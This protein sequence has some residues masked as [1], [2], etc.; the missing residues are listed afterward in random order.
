MGIAIRNKTEYDTR[1]ARRIV[2][3]V[4][5]DLDADNV[6]V[7]IYYRR[8]GDGYS[9]G[10]YRPWWYAKGEDRPQITVAL[11]RP[12]VELACYTPYSRKRDQGPVFSLRCW[13]E[14]LIAIVA[15]EGMHH[16]QRNTPAGKRRFVENQCDWAAYRAVMRWREEARERAQD[17]QP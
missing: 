6:A 5:R 17:R 9:T 15:H 10:H 16:R 12:G 4:L 2:R 3:Q 13:R 8:N 14:A 11:P 1:E 7:T